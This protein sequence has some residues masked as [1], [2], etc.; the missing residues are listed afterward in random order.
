LIAIVANAVSVTSVLVLYSG[1]TGQ[2]GDSHFLPVLILAPIAIRLCAIIVFLPL[3][4]LLD[5]AGRTRLLDY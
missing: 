5:R 4:A 2:Q 1:L 3:N